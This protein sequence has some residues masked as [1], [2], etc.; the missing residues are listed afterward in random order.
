[1]SVGSC[2]QTPSQVWQYDESDNDAEALRQVE[3]LRK[4]FTKHRHAQRHAADELLR[5]QARRT[6]A[7]YTAQPPLTVPPSG[8]LSDTL[9]QDGIRRSVRFYSTLQSP[10]G[11]WPGDYGGPMF[12]LPGLVITCHVTGTQP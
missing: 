10:D 8:K 4:T 6:V 1:M 2:Q 11:H 9:L 12:L 3:D 5:L 7:D